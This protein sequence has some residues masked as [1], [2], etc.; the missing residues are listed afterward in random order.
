MERRH[1]MERRNGEAYCR[2]RVCV[3]A[4]IW[5]VNPWRLGGGAGRDRK[6][7][8]SEQI[9]HSQKFQL[10]TLNFLF[11]YFRDPTS[12][13]LKSLV[14]SSDF[15]PTQCRSQHAGMVAEPLL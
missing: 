11:E 9:R 6:S 13:N 1:V 4:L 7:Q 8:F 2:C 10:S 3:S 12:P 15:L 5:S 14:V